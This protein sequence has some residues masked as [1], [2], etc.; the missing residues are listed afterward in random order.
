MRPK[1]GA[2][3]RWLT[4]QGCSETVECPQKGRSLGGE[5]SRMDRLD[6][7]CREGLIGFE[8][9]WG[10]GAPLLGEPAKEEV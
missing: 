6:R 10:V 3:I 5:L 2:K 4:W 7:Y 8:I 1:S 9:Y